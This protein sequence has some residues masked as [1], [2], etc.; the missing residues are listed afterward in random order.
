M[1]PGAPA[2]QSL[3]FLSSGSGPDVN[4]FNKLISHNWKPWFFTSRGSL[5][6]ACFEGNVS[7]LRDVQVTVLF[8]Y[9]GSE[10]GSSVTETPVIKK[11]NGLHLT[12]P[13]AHDTD[14]GKE[15]RFVL[16]CSKH[17]L[18]W[19]INISFSLERVVGLCMSMLLIRRSRSA[20]MASSAV[21][22]VPVACLY[23]GFPMHNT[24]RSSC[25]LSQSSLRCIIL[26]FFLFFIPSLLQ[27]A[28][29]FNSL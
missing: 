11:H 29:S 14:S 18:L 25:F 4:T 6:I 1:C 8:L 27:P 15:I 7:P 13:D 21:E 28:S 22:R 24:E 10:K 3:S 17:V 23:L 12:L 16:F 19:E 9:S 2:G 20:S 26:S 5:T